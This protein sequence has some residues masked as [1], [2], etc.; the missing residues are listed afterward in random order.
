MKIRPIRSQFEIDEARAVASLDG[1]H[2]HW[3]TH[4]IRR[5]N[6]EIIGTLSVM[7]CVLLWSH[8][9]MLARESIQV[10][11]FFEGLLANQSRVVAVPCPKDSMYLK[12]MAKADSGFA[13]LGDVQLFL[14][15]L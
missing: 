9:K 13:N 6:E 4:I 11:E 1:S 7:P 10:R 3:P 14:K 15:G 12:H 8:H 5:D 2:I